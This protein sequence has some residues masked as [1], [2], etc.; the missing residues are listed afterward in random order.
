MSAFF[1]GERN[2]VGVGVVP[3]FRSFAGALKVVRT[4]DAQLA[5]GARNPAQQ[6]LR[7]PRQLGVG[8]RRLV[9]AV[10]AE[11]LV[12]AFAGKHGFNLRGG[13]LVDEIQGHG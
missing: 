11:E 13:N 10:A 8:E 2:A 4:A 3:I 1:N 5:H 12:G 6:P 7:C 9:N